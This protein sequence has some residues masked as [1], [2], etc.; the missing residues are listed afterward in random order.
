MRNIAHGNG[1]HQLNWPLQFIQIV[2]T[3]AILDRAFFPI[4]SVYNGVFFMTSYEL[5]HVLL[6]TA[7][8]I[9]PPSTASRQAILF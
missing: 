9:R 5:S 6:C 2:V 1:F 3:H 7:D 4:Q 8:C